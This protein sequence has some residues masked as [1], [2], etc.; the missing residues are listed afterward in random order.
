MSNAGDFHDKQLEMEL[1][2]NLLNDNA[3]FLEICDSL[4]PDDFYNPDMAK[5]YQAYSELYQKE[6]QID[7]TYLVR[8]SGV[9]ASI[10][11]ECIDVGFLAANI[12]W[13]ARQIKNHSQRRKMA[14]SLL[15]LQ[16]QVGSM[17][18]LEFAHKLSEIASDIAL[19]GNRARV[20]STLELS[21][22]VERSQHE[23]AT[24]PGHI[25]GIKTGLHYLDKTLR[26]LQPKSLTLIAA[27]TG[28][29]K[30]TLALNLFANI[31][32]QGQKILFISNENDV[33]MNLD[34]LSGIAGSRPLKEITSGFNPENVV[35]EFQ[36]AFDSKCMFLSDNAPR[37]IDE[38]CGLIRKYT[39]QHGVEVVIYDYIG[40]TALAETGE[41]NRMES[42]EQ[43]LARWT[44]QLLQTAR[45]QDVH[46]ILVA[47]LNRQGNAGGKPTKTE[48]AGCFR[49]AQKA[50]SMLLFWQDTNGQDVLTVEKNRTGQAGVNIAV[51]FN[52]SSQKIWDTGLYDTKAKQVLTKQGT[53]PAKYDGRAAAAGDT[54]E[55]EPIDIQ[56]DFPF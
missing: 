33:Q 37:T 1:I 10:L 43:R 11:V 56:E 45:A 31:A 8:Q 27:A 51:T 13:R 18:P 38:V 52:R 39:I 50:H 48:L 49:M 47:Q 14:R 2:G 26:G 42:E 17:E 54:P 7:L 22:I 29:G 34:R 5:S 55:P 19:T 23:R 15:K 28:F 41:A 16:Q 9:N 36:Q 24:E 25:K 12:Q 20:Y 6:K 46:L 32:K 4:R 3:S 53:I 44:A 21:E 35:N 40:E 30:T